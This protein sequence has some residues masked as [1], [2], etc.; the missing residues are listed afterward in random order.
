[1]G[2]PVILKSKHRSTDTNKNKQKG[3]RSPGLA[4]PHAPPRMSGPSPPWNGAP[5]SLRWC[6]VRR[7]CGWE[8]E[9]SASW[10]I[11]AIVIRQRVSSSGL[12]SPVVP[13]VAR[14]FCVKCRVSL[15]TCVNAGRSALLACA[16]TCC[17]SL[18][19]LCMSSSWSRPDRAVPPINHCSAVG[20]RTNCSTF[21]DALLSTS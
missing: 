4:P 5:G 21:S 18:R 7:V 20:G 11:V 3:Q 17:E 16:G 9:L 8:L 1:V 2:G 14:Q 10:R 13:C 15:V 19:S 12:L 6:L